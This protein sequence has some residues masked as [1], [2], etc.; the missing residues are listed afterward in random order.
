ML[1]DEWTFSLTP[2]STS[3]ITPFSKVVDLPHD[4]SVQ[5][6]FDRNAPAGNDGAYLP[7]GKGVYTKT[8][9]LT[10]AQL[11]DKLYKLLF[12]GVYDRSTVSVNG[13]E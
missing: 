3:T 1:D 2:D 8:I 11:K 9:R 10:D 12:E 6:P 4:W 7:T 13:H 5:L